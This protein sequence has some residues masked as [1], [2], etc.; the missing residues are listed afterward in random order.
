KQLGQC[1]KILQQLPNGEGVLY[2]ITMSVNDLGKI[3]VY[4]L[5]YFLAK[6]AERHLTQI[7]Q[8]AVEYRALNR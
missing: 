6:H 5:V 8:V 7:E 3:N 1:E 2:R 4:E